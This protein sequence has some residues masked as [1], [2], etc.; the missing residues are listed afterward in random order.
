MT[1]TPATRWSGF[2]LLLVVVALAGCASTT[3]RLPVLFDAEGSAVTYKRAEMNPRRDFM[4]RFFRESGVECAAVH[5]GPSSDS[6]SVSLERL[7]TSDLKVVF[8]VDMFNEGVDV[9]AIDTVMMLRPTESRIVWL[10]Q[11]GRGDRKSVV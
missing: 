5:A 10:Q 4:R 6:R 9:P 7:A 8:A 3:T 1:C 2:S 11:F